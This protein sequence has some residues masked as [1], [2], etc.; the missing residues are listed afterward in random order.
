MRG[1]N[2][3]ISTLPH[4]VAQF[5]AASVIPAAPKR[6]LVRKR[7]ESKIA[8]ERGIRLQIVVESGFIPAVD[9]LDEER[10]NQ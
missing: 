8:A 4:S 2:D 5:R 1:R 9:L 3:T 6:R 7:L 10:P